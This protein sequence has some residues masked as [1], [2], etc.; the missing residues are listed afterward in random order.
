M[1]PG[2][3]KRRV[4]GEF[5]LLMVAVSWGASFVAV[6]YVLGWL[7]PL[8]FLW[9]R[10]VASFVLLTALFPSRILR[11]KWS[12]IKAGAII[13]FFLGI[14]YMPQTIA[15]QLTSVNMVAF[16]TGLYVVFVPM[17]Q[18]VLLRKKPG[19]LSTAGAV[20]SLV[21]LGVLCLEPGGLRFGLGEVLGTLCAVGFAMHIIAVGKFAPS[22]DPVTIA[23]LQIGFAGI[24]TV[25]VGL[26]LEPLPGVLP[27]APLACM[28]YLT[29]CNV[30]GAML[31]QNWAQQV[32]EPTR[33]A[34]LLATE[35]VFA[36][37][38]SYFILHEAIGLK[39][40]VGDALI[41]LGMI[42]S[43]V[44]GFG[45]AAAVETSAKSGAKTGADD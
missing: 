27:A 19:W 36:A 14:A 22:E 11:A 1:S 6:K 18:A 44:E 28:V 26:F 35:P 17:F 30:I 2:Y 41:F 33:A 3:G 43:Q 7:G 45:A 15:M 31:V 39:G 13:G 8:T 10:F 42:M 23:T 5:L 38:A 16:L 21:G 34:L 40:F 20:T 37:I 12:T 29:V 32:T 25:V 9:L 24:L 4:L